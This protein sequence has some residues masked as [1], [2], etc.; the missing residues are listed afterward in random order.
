MSNHLFYFCAYVINLLCGAVLLRVIYIRFSHPIANVYARG[1]VY[2][3]AMHFSLEFYEDLLMFISKEN[4]TELLKHLLN[5]S[6]GFIILN[7]INRVFF[8]KSEGVE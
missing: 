7:L 3:I 4:W 2:L 1:A 6:L 8:N 5:T